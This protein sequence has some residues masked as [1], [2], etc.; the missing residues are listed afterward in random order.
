MT[1]SWGDNGIAGDT[2]KPL[3][4]G[5]HSGIKIPAHGN[6]ERYGDFHKFERGDRSKTP[7]IQS[8]IFK[9]GYPGGSIVSIVG[10]PK[11]GKTTFVLQEAMLSSQ[12]SDVLY[13]YNESPRSRFM[14]IVSRHLDELKIQERT[15]NRLTFLDMFGV[16]MGSAQY[17]AIE[18]WVN[19]IFANKIDEWLQN[20][21]NPSMIVIDSISKPLRSYTAQV[22]YAVQCFTDY[23]WKSMKKHQKYPVVIMVSQKS[24]SMKWDKDNED[25]LGGM[26]VL[27]DCDGSIIV[28]KDT[29]LNEYQM[30]AFHVSIGKTYHWIQITDMRDIDV[31]T[32]RHIL[33]KKDGRLV[34]GRVLGGHDDGSME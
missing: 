20:A 17:S 11:S 13:L 19:N 15:V 31:D 22:Y 8:H 16:K 3:E 10:V 5:S 29:I 28:G 26:G 24:G 25:V 7:V 34:V 2:N 14:S 21:K 33:A 1:T 18:G 12:N 9:G 6:G 23:M 32:D 30:K 4:R 27:H